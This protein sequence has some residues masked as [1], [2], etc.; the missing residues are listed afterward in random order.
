MLLFKDPILYGRGLCRILV[1]HQAKYRPLVMGSMS[2]DLYSGL[3]KKDKYA[4]VAQ[5]LKAQSFACLLR[6][7]IIVK[8]AYF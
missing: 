8:G 7:S 1:S 3:Q 6:S 4:G 2:L 5:W